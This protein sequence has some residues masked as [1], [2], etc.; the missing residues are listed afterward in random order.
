[1][2]N[3]QVVVFSSIEFY[4]LNDLGE[5]VSLT[6]D[7]VINVENASKAINNVGEGKWLLCTVSNMSEALLLYNS[8][9]W[10]KIYKEKMK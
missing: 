2:N 3:E 7:T 4:V 9:Q 6:N 8:M 10:I 5:L 1:M